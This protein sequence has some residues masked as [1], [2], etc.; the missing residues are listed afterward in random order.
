MIDY[1]SRLHQ[2]SIELLIW[3]FDYA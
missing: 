3:W 1:V 2:V